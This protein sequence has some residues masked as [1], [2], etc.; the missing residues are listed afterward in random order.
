MAAFL[1][2]GID[3][4]VLSID[5]PYDDA[6]DP[7]TLRDDLVSVKVWYSTTSG[8]NPLN[9]EGTLAFDGLSLS[10]TIKGLQP[11]TTYY[12]KYALISAIDTNVYTVS[13]QL[14]ET[15][16]TPPVAGK[17][18]S[19]AATA[20]AFTYNTAG[21]SPQ[22]ANSTVTATTYNFINV[23]PYYE[24]YIDG[25]LVANNNGFSLTYTPKANHSNMP[26][27]IT[28]RVRD[29][30]SS[31]PVVAEDSIV[32][33]GVIP[34]SSAITIVNSN[35]AHSLFTSV[36]GS[37][38]YTG[39]GTRIQVLQGSTYLTVD[40]SAT[41]ASGTFKITTSSDYITAS[42]DITNIDNNT[43]VVYGNHSNMTQTTA[44]IT[45][46][47]AVKRTDGTTTNFISYQNFTKSIQGE[48]GADG[49]SVTI[50]GSVNTSTS[51][52]GYPSS[53]GG[54]T[55]DGYIVADT[56]HLWIWSG[57]TW[58]DA[59]NIAGPSGR[60]GLVSITAYVLRKQTAALLTIAPSDTTGFTV[61]TDY[62]IIG[63][64]GNVSTT[65][66][67]VITPPTATVGEVV[68]YSFGRYNPNNLTVDG[69]APGKTKWAVPIAASIFQDIKSDNWTGVS[70]TATTPFPSGAAGYY[71]K[72]SGGTNNADAGLYAEN[73]F[74][75]GQIV[76][77]SL[78]LQGTTIPASGITG[79]AAV[80][81]SG[82]KNDVGL[83]NVSN[84][85]PANQAK[86]GIEAAITI[87][88]GGIAMNN[89]GYVKG[90]QSDFNTGTGF[91]LGYTSDNKYKFSIGNPSAQRI[92]W[93]GETFTIVGTINTS[94]TIAGV[95]AGTVVAN[96]S[97]ALQASNFNT[98]L[99]SQLTAGVT[100]VLA[101][102]G[103]D[104]RLKID[105]DT[106]KII[107]GHKDAVANYPNAIPGSG[108]AGRTY[109][110][111]TS[112]GIAMGRYGTVDNATTTPSITIDGATGNATFTGT[113]NASNIIGSSITGGTLNTTTSGV[114]RLAINEEASNQITVYGLNGGRLLS[115]GGTGIAT[116]YSNGYIFD[117]VMP[118]PITSNPYATG[119]TI[120][121]P[122]G[123]V[124][125]LKVD[126]N[127]LG[128]TPFQIK[129]PYP[130]TLEEDPTPENIPSASESKISL[131]EW[132]LK[133][134][135]RYGLDA[136]MGTYF[137]NLAT[138]PGGGL[139]IVKAQILSHYTKINGYEE[140]LVA[141][142]FLTLRG[143]S[144]IESAVYIGGM[145]AGVN[146]EIGVRSGPTGNYALA[147]VGK[148]IHNGITISTPPNDTGYY[149]RG[150][151]TWAVLPLF[152]QHYTNSTVTF[153]S[154]GVGIPATGISG[155]IDAANDIVAF[156]T[157][158]L[159]LK[160]NIKPITNPI[161]KI[162][163]IT[164]NT[165]TWKPEFKD[166][167]GHQGEDIGVIA[168]EIEKILPQ[169]VRTNSNG[170]KAVRYEK[171]IPL[172]IQAI[173]Y[174]Q[175]QI[176]RLIA[177]KN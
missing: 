76:A 126:Q 147:I 87:G 11:D 170:Y 44:R 46:T 100:N 112:S 26:D 174:Q 173:K 61:P 16:D 176:D 124:R 64:S 38:T 50:L 29:G 151:G 167:H 166:E 138:T 45:Y 130:F 6:N 9:G 17:T 99:Q 84:L 79:L 54:A 28:V 142:K 60:D 120:W 161:D 3:Y 51:L 7:L 156:S 105:A 34:G 96:A 89:G 118:G 144:T 122:Y 129:G 80:A 155:R 127:A 83:D 12:V 119:Q 107:L 81:T 153:G 121:T 88:S 133:G 86:T 22:P 106:G 90:G 111:V 115:L 143:G 95:T 10:I 18:V 59:G 135:L 19:L 77:T 163:Q 150:D 159:N 103:A 62:P 74:I 141:A 158:D 175:E 101:G 177:N 58:T 56:G 72:K 117:I 140:E 39:S 134:K 171:I 116:S 48:K 23:T 114:H 55:G 14:S 97:G 110:T 15:T 41:P 73:A 162:K 24:W 33:F 36:N 113:V 145:D 132:T 37:V 57:S 109:L 1:Y 172:L 52:P 168:Q 2:S 123:P 66:S 136:T 42:N 102:T 146:G 43:T 149:L 8:F 47:I 78:T 4:L 71:I 91:F 30:N 68:W 65:E 94:S 21:E 69:V 169:A 20:L 25:V 70:P 35:P 152:P 31:S 160:T 104:Y 131:G 139:N 164:G 93:D 27:T 125:S 108:S 63:D 82:S 5:T 92:T 98:T 49:T 157:S 128:C 53:Y 32:M 67:W 75:K 40:N 154:F 85:T 165:F 137:E 13:S 148:F